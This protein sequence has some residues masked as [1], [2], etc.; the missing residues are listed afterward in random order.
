VTVFDKILDYLNKGGVVALLVGVLLA[1]QQGIWVWGQTLTK[2]E[3]ERDQWKQL[4]LQGTRLAEEAAMGPTRIIGMAP[5][6]PVPAS[7]VQ[8]IDISDRLHALE[9]AMNRAGQD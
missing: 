7:Q 9:G 8:A 1:G 4:A 6:K 5:P 2:T 3:A